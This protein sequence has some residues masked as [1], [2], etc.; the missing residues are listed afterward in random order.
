MLIPDPSVGLNAHII[1]VCGAI[2]QYTWGPY[3]YP[4]L[5]TF[6]DL[7]IRYPKL[8]NNPI[9]VMGLSRVHWNCRMAGSFVYSK[10]DLLK[11]P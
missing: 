11:Q 5:P 7:T 2:K 10:L 4:C 9:L 6:N 3:P 1:A 8:G